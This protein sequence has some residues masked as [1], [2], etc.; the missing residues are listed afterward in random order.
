MNEM[1]ERE[2][3]DLCEKLISEIASEKKFMTVKK[4][5]SILKLQAILNG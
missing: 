4:L 1:Y 5:F 2:G 3:R